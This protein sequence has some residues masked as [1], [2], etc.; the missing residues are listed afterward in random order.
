MPTP[1]RVRD[2]RTDNEYTVR[3]VDPEVHEVLDEAAV[4]HNG[5]DLPPTGP[6]GDTDAAADA[7]A[8]DYDA[9]SRD[10]LRDAVKA[11]NE[12]RGEG[13]EPPL[14]VSGAKADL[15]AVLQADDEATQAAV[16]TPEADQT[17]ANTS[18][19]GTPS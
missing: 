14:V 17:A 1:T 7:V 19:E 3:Y 12:A 16:T 6:R 15:V 5:Y 11:R 8:P 10:E 9:L 2:K 18:T 13:Q 4:D